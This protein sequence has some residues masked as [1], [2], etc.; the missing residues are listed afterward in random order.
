MCDSTELQQAEN[1]DSTASQSE[2]TFQEL[3]RN[4]E[5]TLTQ[6]SSE[7]EQIKHISDCKCDVFDSDQFT[8]QWESVVSQQIEKLW[9]ISWK[10]QNHAVLQL[11]WI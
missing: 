6:E 2:Y 4:I 9:V 7:E 1:D 11:L 5:H 10:L 3:H 8:D